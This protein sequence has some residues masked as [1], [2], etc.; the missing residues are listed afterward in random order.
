MV[1][2]QFFYRKDTL[3]ID[4]VYRDCKT[5]SVKFNDRDTYVEVNVTNPAYEVSRDHKVV[6]NK[7]GKAVGTKPSINPLQP[8]PTLPVAPEAVELRAPDGSVWAIRVDN[9]GVIKAKKR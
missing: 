5:N 2:I 8:T 7:E 3:Q 6:L 1:K 9:A 4:A